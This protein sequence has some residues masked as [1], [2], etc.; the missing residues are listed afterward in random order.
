[1]TTKYHASNPEEIEGYAS[2]FHVPDQQGDLMQ[3]GAFRHTTIVGLPVLW[4]HR[5]YIPIGKV[6]AAKEDTKGLWFR[7]RLCTDTQLGREAMSLVR[8]GVLRGLSIGFR[9]IKASRGRGGLRR[10]IHKVTLTEISLVTFPS[11]PKAEVYLE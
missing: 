10:V 4:Q 6:V 2:V 8:D 7:L 5:P 1:M 9:A 11:N 3:P